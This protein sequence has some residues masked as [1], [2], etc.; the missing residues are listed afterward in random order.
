M[1]R[2]ASISRP[3]APLLA[4][5]FGRERELA[6]ARDLF[7]SSRLVT[8]TGPGG[9]GKTSLAAAMSSTVERAF[10][11]GTRFVE[12]GAL[13]SSDTVA[14]TVATNLGLSA[15]PTMDAE[16]QLRRHVADRS[17]LLVLDNCEHVLPGCRRLVSSLLTVSSELR[18]LTT[19]REPLRIRGE[20]VIVVRPLSVP[21]KD[22]HLTV[23]ELRDYPAVAMLEA[24]AKAVNDQFE[25]TERDRSAVAELVARLDGMPLAIELAAA[26]LRSLPVHE[27]LDRINDRFALL[28]RGD[29]TATPHHHS[30]DALV[31]W[32][33][34]LCSP[35]EQLLW[36]R[37]AAF[38][39]SPALEG[40]RAVCG[41]EPLEGTK[42]LD[43]LD[44]L[45]SK[46]ILLPELTRGE[47][48][49]RILETLRDFALE[50]AQGSEDHARA[51]RAHVEYYRT[52]ATQTAKSFFGPGQVDSI[53]R[54]ESDFT[55]IEMA[56]SG[57]LQDPG[58]SRDALELG[59]SLRFFW[60]TG[61]LREGKRWLNRALATDR[62]ESVERGNALWAAASVAAL[63]GELPSAQ[64]FLK[65]AR[66][67]A[68]SVG[69]P[70]LAAHVATWTGQTALTS[71]D[72][73]AAREA[74]ETAYK[75]H[76]DLS[77]A[78]GRMMTL[79]LLG[80]VRSALGDHQ[81]ASDACQEAISLS[82]SLGE[83]WG[84]S[85][86][87]W[88]LAFDAWTRQ[89][90]DVAGELAKQSLELKREFRD[91][92]GTALVVNLLAG[93]ALD[94]HDP[95]K[96]AQLLGIVEA[97]WTLLDTETKAFG[98]VLAS[99]YEAITRAAQERLGKAAFQRAYEAGRR[100]EP[101]RQMSLALGGAA[102]AEKGQAS[103][104]SGSDLL[105]PRERQVAS[106]LAEG[107]SNR[108][109]ATRLVL[110]QR[111]VEVHVEHILSKLGFRSRTEAGVWAAQ[112]L[113]GKE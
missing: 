98:P 86:A 74:F 53:Q 24:R 2:H 31:Q 81:G 15:L 63:H 49:Y 25:I 73:E 22:R 106:L 3:Y 89:G 35:D 42:L 101:G 30:L 103:A 4:D 41:F 95:K 5:M 111:T 96:A 68:R 32:S 12:L 113:Q 58:R 77:D 70:R 18:V 76:V 109:I 107:L 88:V 50:R 65:E 78:E 59:S 90:L 105:T 39:G 72:L 23:G 57:L 45:V 75:V 56:F 99:R 9:V 46:S 29:L 62:T 94:N 51:R 92:L 33:Y 26:R 17:L 44:G 13:R 47:M 19:S 93:I 108:A 112:A 52:W 82:E 102:A 85:Y 97:L 40:I 43:S 20:R 14:E 54:L 104:V 7:S 80:F 100:L 87:L 28:N 110:S 37:L 66:E 38:S 11:E 1:S 64:R 60:I 36:A 27:L 48:R 67:I 16:E 91:D 21:P 6:D 79:F 55:N 84:R 61:H 8:L 10:R 34:D 69:D 83:T 71:G